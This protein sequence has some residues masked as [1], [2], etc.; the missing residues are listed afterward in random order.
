MIIKTAC[1][2]ILDD[3]R[4]IEHN[5][6]EYPSVIDIESVNM[7]TDSLPYGLLTSVYI[8]TPSR[9]MAQM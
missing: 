8:S 9:D 2:I 4:A 7:N 1:K 5:M 6:D 3:I